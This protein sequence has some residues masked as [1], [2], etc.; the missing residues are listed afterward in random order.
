[1]FM[2]ILTLF[3]KDGEHWP[4]DAHGYWLVTLKG[5]ILKNAVRT[6]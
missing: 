2:G 5:N 4:T 3:L 1:M 6:L